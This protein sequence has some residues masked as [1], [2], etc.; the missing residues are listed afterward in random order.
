[1]SNKKHEWQGCVCKICRKIKDEGH[2]WQGSK[3]V[4]C[5]GKKKMATCE[6]CSKK[7][8]KLNTAIGM[9][10]EGVMGRRDLCDDCFVHVMETGRIDGTSDRLIL[11]F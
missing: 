3:C 2:D 9:V 5:G 1:M 10:G 7:V 11:R 6:R 4:I 8:P